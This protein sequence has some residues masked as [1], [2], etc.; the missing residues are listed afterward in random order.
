MSAQTD[1][2]FAP[3]PSIVLL[4][5]VWRDNLFLLEL[6]EINRLEEAMFLDVINSVEQVPKSFGEVVNSQVLD[7]TLCIGR[8]AIGIFNLLLES[9]LENFVNVVVHKRRLSY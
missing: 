5:Y 8:K 6:I 7:Q 4:R 1:L 2:F 3:T 9:H